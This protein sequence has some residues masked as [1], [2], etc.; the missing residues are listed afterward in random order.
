VL[1]D[2]TKGITDRKAKAAGPKLTPVGTEAS[3]TKPSITSD[4]PGAFMAAE[5]LRDT[6]IDLR[7][8]AEDLR[9]HADFFEQV[10]AGLDEVSGFASTL[11]LDAKATAA[12]LKRQEEAE[13]DRKARERA[14][15]AKPE[16]LPELDVDADIAEG[17][18]E[19][20][21]R[22][23]KEAQAAVFTS[24]DAEP[25]SPFNSLPRELPSK[26]GWEC[27]DHGS[28]DLKTTTSRKGRTYAV[29]V[30]SGCDNFER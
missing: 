24:A 4:L 14:A 17:F 3:P 25:E 2:M 10:A 27:P 8:K 28:K 7:R 26:G 30:V 20:L 13:G 9:R 21:D 16:V 23:S 5:G 19:R 22:L 15:A 18:T 29:C 1:D 6:A 11:Q 12:E